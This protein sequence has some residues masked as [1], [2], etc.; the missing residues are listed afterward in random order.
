[1]IATIAT[2]GAV[3]ACGT[4]AAV[5]AVF[6]GLLVSAIATRLGHARLFLATFLVLAVATVGATSAGY[7]PLSERAEQI[8]VD[9]LGATRLYV[10]RD[11]LKLLPSLPAFGYGLEAFPRVYPKVESER[12]ALRWPQVSHE[13]AHN[14]L[15]DTLLSKG[16]L[17][18]AIAL[19]ISASGFWTFKRLPE[20]ARLPGAMCL[21]AHMAG[22]TACMFFTPQLP[23]LIYFYLPVCLLWGLSNDGDVCSRDDDRASGTAVLARWERTGR[24]LLFRTLGSALIIYGVWLAVWDHSVFRAKELFD[25]GK[26][27]EAVEGFSLARQTAPPGVSAE[28]WFSRELILNGG[29]DFSP[30]IGKTLRRSLEASIQ[31]EEDFE[32]SYILLSALMIR[33]GQSR[34]AEIVLRRA[35]LDFPN[36]PTAK[37]LL[38]AAQ[39]RENA[40]DAGW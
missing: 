6:I 10:W 15:L 39:S 29:S 40:A 7:G 28:S 26:L 21:G 1:M 4:R 30:G 8:R 24:S 20:A 37:T 9:P 12:T 2:L 36:W 19:G 11:S 13:S 27:A 5:L 16:P 38:A 18:L 33:E 31:H 3:L 14:Y 32:N 23:T 25:S 22:L 34:Q 17:G 35:L